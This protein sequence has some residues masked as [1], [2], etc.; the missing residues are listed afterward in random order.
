MTGKIDELEKSFEQVEEEVKQKEDVILRV[1]EAKNKESARA[2]KHSLI[3]ILFLIFTILVE[4][5]GFIYYISNYGVLETTTEQEGIYNFQ[6]SEGNM[7][8]TD[9]SLEEMKELIEAN[10]QD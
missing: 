4:T 5:C 10:G 2:S 3:I 9:L 8:S 1:I 6:D 7:V